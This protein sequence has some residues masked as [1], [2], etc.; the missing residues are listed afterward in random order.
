V[1]LLLLL[2]QERLPAAQCCAGCPQHLGRGQGGVQVLC[3][4]FE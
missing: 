3:L 2:R 4:S 1:R